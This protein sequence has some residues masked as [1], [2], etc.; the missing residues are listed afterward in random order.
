[1]V[2]AKWCQAR[3]DAEANKDEVCSFEATNFVFLVRDVCFIFDCLGV[4]AAVDAD[5]LAGD[6]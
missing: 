1:M 4:Y 6:V 5:D 3:F 2:P